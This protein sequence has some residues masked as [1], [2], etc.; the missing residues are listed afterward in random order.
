LQPV[1]QEECIIRDS[2]HPTTTVQLPTVWFWD[3]EQVL[4]FLYQDSIQYHPTGAIY[5]SQ[6]LG[7]LVTEKVRSVGAQLVNANGEAYIHPLETR[8][9]NASGVIRECE[10]GRGVEVPGGAKRCMAGYSDDRDPGW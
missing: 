1:V 4:P 3:T 9:V 2:R 6:I 7:A 8:D 5:P 10:E